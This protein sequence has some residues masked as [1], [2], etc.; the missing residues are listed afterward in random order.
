MNQCVEERWKSL[1]KNKQ[2][3]ILRDLI[4]SVVL[5]MDNLPECVTEDDWNDLIEDTNVD[6]DSFNGVH[7]MVVYIE[8]F[9]YLYLNEG[10]PEVT[11]L[12][13]FLK[14][15]VDKVRVGDHQL[16]KGCIQF[17][18]RMWFELNTQ[19]VFLWLFQNQNVL[20]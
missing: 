9:T 3:R 8:L 4:F 19:A 16:F 7:M 18:T 6:D 13:N 5:N 20:N 11:I 1:D 2:A 17:N 14:S 15:L 10:G 12:V